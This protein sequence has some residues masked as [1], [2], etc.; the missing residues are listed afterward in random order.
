MGTGWGPGA[1]GHHIRVTPE[2]NPHL[3]GPLRWPQDDFG[4]LR[5]QSEVKHS[6]RDGL[7]TL[8]GSLGLQLG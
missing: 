5:T 6:S 3:T 2:G 8:V 4:G 7:E 1:R